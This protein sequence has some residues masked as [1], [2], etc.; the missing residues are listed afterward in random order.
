MRFPGYRVPYNG[1]FA[2]IRHTDGLDGATLISGMI[3]GSTYDFGC[4]LPNLKRIVLHP[5][6]PRMA[7][8]MLELEGSRRCSRTV[9]K[10]ETC[11]GCSLIDG[12]DQCFIVV[13]QS[14]H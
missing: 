8:P 11:T 2:L 9:K 13:R 10:H 5:A 1:G 14:S 6:G 7:L 4:A 3:E 12:A